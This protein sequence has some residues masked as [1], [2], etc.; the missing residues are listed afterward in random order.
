[1]RLI[2]AGSRTLSISSE[3]IEQKLIENNITNV[4]TIICGCGGTNFDD[5]HNR[6]KQGKTA[7]DRGVDKAG[8]VYAKEK[9]IQIIYAPALW[10]D[11]GRSAG[12][13]RNQGMARA[14]EA[15]LLIWDGKSRGSASMKREME[16]LNKP[17]YEII[18]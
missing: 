13:R 8:E 5:I 17:I 6:L 1:M 15:L 18:L 2:I 14:A 4:S 3:F 12:P 11:Q 9:N 16:K 7:S 10:K